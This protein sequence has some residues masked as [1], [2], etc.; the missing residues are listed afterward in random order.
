MNNSKL[1]SSHQPP[2]PIHLLLIL[3]SSIFT[4]ELLIHWVIL[5]LPP[6]SEW[7]QSLIDSILL[8]ALTFPPLYFFVFRR[9][10][11]EI[12]E[13]KLAEEKMRNI[14]SRLQTL[15][16]AIEQSPV[17]TVI[18]DLAGNIVFVNPKFTETTGYTAE[19]AIGQNPRIL[20][21]NFKTRSEYK[22]LWDTILSG[23]SWH[24]LFKNK[25]KN[26]EHYWESATISPVKD[27]QGAITHFLAVKEDIT[28]RKQTEKLAAALYEIS[29]AVYLTANVNE[30]FQSIHLLLTGVIPGNNFFIALLTGNGKA[31]S[32]PYF[33][34]EMDGDD[35]PDI[36]LENSQSL[37]V[38]VLNTKRPLLLNE[39]QLQDRY[40]TGRNI[41]VLGS[42]TKCWLGVP[43]IIRD[44]AI[45][46]MAV[47]DYHNGSAYAQKDMAL[48]ELAASQIAIGI[49][50]KQSEDALRASALELERF[51]SQLEVS[52]NQA[53]ELAVRAIHAE[54]MIRES[55]TRYRAVFDT[56]ND[57]II[58]ADSAG[59]IVDWNPGA[60]RIFGYPKDEVCGQP[61]T[62]LLPVRHQAG[63]LSGME[64]V[65][66][67]G[68]KHVI[69]RT[70]ELE[71]RRKD[72]SEFPLEISLSEWRTGDHL[73]FSAV[74][75]DITERK[76]LKE[77]LQ[78]QASTDA[79]TGIFNRRYFLQLALGELKRANRLNRSL[80]VVLID[81]D[82]FKHVN[83][84]LGHAAGDQ[85]LLA[86]T[87]ICKENIREIDMFARFGGDEFALLLLE[88]SYEQAYV[89]VDR[90]RGAVNAQPISLDEKVISITISSGI[91]HLSDH[92]EAFDKLLSQADQALY[93]A[94]ETGRNKVVIY[95]GS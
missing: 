54:E 82:H 59:N 45:G 55:E 81:I 47:Q 18:T 31:L 3:A 40:S 75:R 28:E 93:R 34:D 74:I 10:M 83:D 64:R 78:Q 92:E 24:G 80:A 58:S 49:E 38:E 68:A 22:E 94:K 52:I 4:I 1:K 5:Y 37:T 73:F 84:T 7:L 53:N 35:W 76:R 61:M 85:A 6:H 57:A 12:T 62:L 13:R 48:L 20:K 51:N 91:A 71:G 60:E 25:R 2:S 79:L 56:A 72:G 36:D 88:A 21:T 90:I 41:G 29:K 27:E 87:K 8:L 69:G 63:H 26:G 39:A 19:E 30:L 15:S 86:F 66:T 33:N 65:R 11:L 23:Q 44:V 16:V 70:V 50:R 32:F 95:E 42:E 89:V 77:E 46:V 14:N 43:L 67:G 9:L 17:T